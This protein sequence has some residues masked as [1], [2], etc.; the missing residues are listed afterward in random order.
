MTALPTN[1][2]FVAVSENAWN[3]NTPNGVPGFGPMDPAEAQRRLALLTG[4]SSKPAQERV[5]DRGRPV[6]RTHIR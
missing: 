5:A 1:P 6:I 4:S 2:S 3:F